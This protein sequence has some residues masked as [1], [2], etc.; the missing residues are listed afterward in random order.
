MG[1]DEVRC[2]SQGRGDRRPRLGDTWDLS[3]HRGPVI[4]KITAAVLRSGHG[5]FTVEDLELA[6]PRE[7]EVLVRMVA[8][9]MCH[10]DLIP[11]D[12]PPEFF[13][14]PE[15]RGH[16]GSGVVEAVGSKVTDVVPGDH[17]VLS[18]TSCGHCPACDRGR[19]PYCFNFGL[20]NMSGGRS[21][22]TSALADGSGAR[23]GSHFFGQSSFASH[24]IVA[25]DSVVKVDHSYDLTLL[26][27][28]GRASC[29]ERV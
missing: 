12:L 8:A 6:E 27:Q 20:H 18:F 15:V 9:G 5:P 3:D 19:R 14:G 13:G 1:A 10:T 16:E 7:D 4:V 2:R 23:I 21:D 28:I 25:Q 26:G 11:R 29:R 22:G 24:A 17:V